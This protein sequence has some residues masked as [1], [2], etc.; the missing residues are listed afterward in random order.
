V[1]LLDEPLSNLD[2]KL[3]LQ[4]RT[5][6]AKLHRRL[7]TTMI[8]VTHDQIEA[9]TLGDRIVIL[10]RGKIQQIDTPMNLY[11]RPRNLFVAGFIGSPAMNFIDGRLMTEPV[12]SFVS[13]DGA[14]RV[15]LGSG[16]G[17]SE[18][19][20]ILGVRPEDLGVDPD[21]SDTIL[22]LVEPVGNEAFVYARAGGTQLV[23]RVPPSAVPQP[24]SRI[25]LQ[26][27]VE[28]LHFFDPTSGARLETRCPQC[29]LRWGSGLR[30]RLATAARR[31]RPAEGWSPPRVGRGRPTPYDM[32]SGERDS[33]PTPFSF[34][35][36][37]FCHPTRCAP[38]RP[39]GG[40]A[41]HRE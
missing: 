31:R 37:H 16:P 26:F 12:A 29:E 6:I 35:I 15:P 38:A 23:A 36:L 5:E 33:D 22:E 21:G 14:I 1:F 11:M 24:D 20:A 9:M 25:G 19:E 8:Y 3:R 40:T 32:N 4:M 39:A 28:R 13:H 41:H 7:G 27:D 30:V 10:D 34:F 17:G 18:R 2:A